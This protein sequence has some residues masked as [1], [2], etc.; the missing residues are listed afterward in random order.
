MEMNKYH[1]A[2]D[3]IKTPPALREKTRQMLIAQMQQA[4]QTQTQQ[5]Q[6]VQQPQMHVL[7]TPAQTQT[8]QPHS[9]PSMQT[10]AR[11]TRR[12]QWGLSAVAAVLVLVIGLSFWLTMA[13]DDDLIVTNLI[14]HGHVENVEL[15]I[16]ALNFINII[17]TEA[18]PPLRFAAAFPLRRNISI[19]EY[20]YLLPT[21][22][23]E[24][25]SEPTGETTAFY[26]DP[27]G[28]PAAILGRAYYQ[29][30]CG[31]VLSLSFTNDP[32]LIVLPIEI[33]GGSQIYG[34]PVGVG[35]I[36]SDGVYQG[37]YMIDEFIF[38]L[39]AEGMEQRQFIY[40]LVHFI[41]CKANND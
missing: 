34:T 6:N 31:S 2:V 30:D 41:T 22:L 18:Q 38:L 24:G 39:T 23:P 14:Q 8:Q 7:Q 19:D 10:K 26:N 21:T 35:F 12:L 40:I 32:A 16:G 36:E 5:V 29:S 13:A 15:Q 28:E 3:K 1:E 20:Q 17:E 4:Q 25:L 33:E 37:V 27:L 9:Q 11:R